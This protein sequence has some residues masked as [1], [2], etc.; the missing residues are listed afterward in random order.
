MSAIDSAFVKWYDDLWS[1]R[2]TRL[3][4]W[5]LMESPLPTLLIVAS[6]VYIVKIYGP[7]AM[8][9]RPAYDLKVF[10]VVYNLSQVVLS[11]YIFY[12]VRFFG[13]ASLEFDSLTMKCF[14]F[15]FSGWNGDYNI[16]C[17]PV[18]KRGAKAQRVRTLFMNE[19]I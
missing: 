7:R 14:Q 1:H 19:A 5:F 13:L 15:F 17:Q 3:D 2:D 11:A 16:F 10:L 12:E 6:Y 9:E 4:G 18:V 8:K